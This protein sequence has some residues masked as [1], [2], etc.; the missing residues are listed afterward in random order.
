MLITWLSAGT[1]VV[2][3][4]HGTSFVAS[5][6]IASD[7]THGNALNTGVDLYVTG[8]VSVYAGGYSLQLWRVLWR[9]A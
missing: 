8:D 6:I 2:P 7:R 9:A 5:V 3:E 1:L 4:A